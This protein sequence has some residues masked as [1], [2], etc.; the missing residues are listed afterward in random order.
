MNSHYS[1][2]SI[3]S[4]LI[5]FVI[6]ASASADWQRWRGPTANGVAA[7]N[8]KPPTSWSATKNII[9]KTILPGR[10]NSSPTIV[11]RRIFLT[12][13][14]TNTQTQ[15][16][17]CYD[18]KDGKMQWKM[19]LN[20]GGLAKK[21]HPKNTHATPTIAYDN[22]T[23]FVVFIN[24]TK[25]QVSAM[26]LDGKL[27]WKANAGTF[28]PKRYQFGY[29]PSPHVHN[30][31]VIIASEVENESFLAAF[32]TATGSMVWRTKR[33]LATSYSSPIVAHI[34]GKDQLLI[35]GNK[36]IT[37]YNPTNGKMLWSVPGIWN[38]TCGTVVWD[39]D[40]V[41]ASGGY[42]QR[43]T[44]AVRADGSKKVLWQNRVNSYEQSMITHNGYLYTVSDS[45]VAFCWNAKTGVEMWKHRLG[46]KVSASLSLVNGNIHISNERG[47][48][49]IY[50][51]SPKQ[52]TLVA[53][54]Q[55][56]TGAFA[57]PA[58]T[59]NRIYKRL[60]IDTPKG[61]RQAL[62]CIGK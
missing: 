37:S 61:P 40:V 26:S 47:K 38:V 34:A 58:Y 33:P 20:K 27:K 54:N 30:G 45:G 23:I 14:D 46:G 2:R 9:W 8:Q 1:T 57:T 18:T 11:G 48:T 25:V 35:S 36:A 12:T 19:L 59:N 52:F 28:A 6:S 51:A 10:G 24:T 3:V 60:T 62:F 43:G 53:Q 31:L 5:C 55:I 21:I 42:P 16:V 39:K 50:K 4:L 41:F 44:M 22:N 56:G 7:P 29:A 17:L 32:H 15:S 49:F 13:S